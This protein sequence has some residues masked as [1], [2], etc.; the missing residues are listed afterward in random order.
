MGAGRGQAVH[1]LGPACHSRDFKA[2]EVDRSGLSH[3]TGRVNHGG[4]ENYKRR[5][6]TQLP[7]LRGGVNQPGPGEVWW[8]SPQPHSMFTTG[9]RPQDLPPPSPETRRPSPQTGCPSP[10]T[11]RP[12]PSSCGDRAPLRRDRARWGSLNSVQPPLRPACS[13]VCPAWPCFPS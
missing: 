8:V 9:K 11:R 10:E 12:A 4:F 6:R 5:S 3:R 13:S 2:G 7:R 1:V